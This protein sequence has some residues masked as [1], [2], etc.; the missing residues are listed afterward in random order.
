MD[1]MRKLTTQEFIDRLSE[2]NPSISVL[3]EYVNCKT[4]IKVRGISCGHEWMGNPH[5]L[6]GGHGCP[7]CRYINNSNRT[8]KTNEQFIEDLRRISPSIEPL[9]I[10]QTSQT[11]IRV[12]CKVCHYEWQV[13][14]N[15]LMNGSGCA[16]CAGLR[17][18][19]TEEFKAELN[20]KNS[21]IMVLGEYSNNRSEIR[22]KCLNCGHEWSPT[23]KSLLMG[24]SCPECSKVGTSFMEQFILAA[25]A[26]V[27]GDDSVSNRNKDAIG[28]ELDIYIPSKSLA[29]EPGSWFWH[30]EI[31]ERDKQKRSVAKE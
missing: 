30:E 15:T 13:K 21:N 26:K 17:K 16:Q 1:D 12:R 23:A 7:T 8:R 28:H 6:L 4:R 22:V 5:D 11:P 18:K 9:D 24:R 3:G 25:F 27:L 2:T 29:I 19:S 31:F 20:S 10:Y 14:P